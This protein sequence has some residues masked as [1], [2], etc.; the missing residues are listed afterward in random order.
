M[1][2]KRGYSGPPIPLL[3]V[4]FIMLVSVLRAVRI[5]RILGE[6]WPIFVGVLLFIVFRAVTDSGKKQ[7]PK[8]PP[9]KA[10]PRPLGF[11]LPKLKGAPKAKK[12]EA[13][14][15]QE[16]PTPEE[17]AEEEARQQR[18]FRQ[19]E[20]KKEREREIRAREEAEYEAQAKLAPA[21][22][23]GA[24]RAIP[25]SAEALRNAFIYAEIFAPPKALR[26]RV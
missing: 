24:A 15:Y 5:D 16:Q 26:R 13:Q 10:E 21:P 19:A 20:E 22:A 25:V 14:V 23:A 3:A 4:G 8:A 2:G 12:K 7:A 18:L 6:D 11:E 9:E 1:A 17:A